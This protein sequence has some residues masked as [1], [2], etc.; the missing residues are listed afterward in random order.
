MFDSQDVSIDGK[1]VENANRA[2]L[3]G[4]PCGGNSD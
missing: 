1:K 3:D 4:L 2:A